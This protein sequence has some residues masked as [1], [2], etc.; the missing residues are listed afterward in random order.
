[1]T[2][3][4]SKVYKC[5]KCGGMFRYL[6]KFNSS[7]QMLEP[8]SG[9]KVCKHTDTHIQMISPCNEGCTYRFIQKITCGLLSISVVATFLPHLH[10]HGC[11]PQHLMAASFPLHVGVSKYSLGSQ[12]CPQRLPAV[13]QRALPVYQTFHASQDTGQDSV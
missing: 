9:G 12:A 3:L 5:N 8:G 7:G 10:T 11:S 2:C 13:R 1:M 4:Q 6:G